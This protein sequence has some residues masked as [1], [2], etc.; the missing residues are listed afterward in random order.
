MHVTLPRSQRSPRRALPT[1]I[2]H[3]RCHHLYRHLSQALPADEFATSR[4]ASYGPT[5]PEKFG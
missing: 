1:A 3:L 5:E 2:A 4:Q